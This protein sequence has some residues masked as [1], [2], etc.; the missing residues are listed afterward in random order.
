MTSI[1]CCL[2]AGEWKLVILVG[3]PA[4]QAHS[5]CYLKKEH[6]TKGGNCDLKRQTKLA[7]LTDGQEAKT[8]QNTSPKKN[9]G[10]GCF[11]VELTP[12]AFSNTNSSLISS[13]K[14]NLMFL[15]RLPEELLPPKPLF[16]DQ[17]SPW[18]DNR[19]SHTHLLL[20]CCDASSPI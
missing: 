19:R 17:I 12:A 2:T 11:R 20:R 15:R 18:V 5:V 16:H 9:T 13:I 10:T 4:T 7:S 14:N 6:N 3:R 8:H 1:S